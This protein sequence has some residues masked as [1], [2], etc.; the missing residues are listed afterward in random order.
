MF[1]LAEFQLFQ[2]LVPTL[3]LQVLAEIFNY[4]NRGEDS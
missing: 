1:Y 4:Y 2:S 3:Q